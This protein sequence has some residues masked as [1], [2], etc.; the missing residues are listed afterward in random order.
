[1]E[2]GE[3][4]VPSPM[5]RDTRFLT[6]FNA[7]AICFYLLRKVK[8]PSTKNGTGGLDRESK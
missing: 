1:M 3:G 4:E 8:V 6:R 5:V 2:E 7:D